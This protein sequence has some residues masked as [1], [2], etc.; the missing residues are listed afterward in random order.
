MAAAQN[1]FPILNNELRDSRR[2]LLESAGN[3]LV[4][5]VVGHG[6]SGTST[7]ANTIAQLLREIP[8]NDNGKGFDVVTLRA[9]D[10]I[11]EWAVERHKPLP[12]KREKQ[13]LTDVEVLQN[14]GDEMR[15]ERSTDDTPDHSAVARRLALKIREARAVA[16]GQKADDGAPVMPDGTHR[17]YLLDS[18]RHP[19]EVHFLRHLY[20][21]AFILVGVV[22]EEEKRIA[23]LH[24]KYDDGGRTN[25]LRF[26][27]R[28]ADAKEKYGQHVAD[29]F[30]LSDFFVDNTVDHFHKDGRTNEGWVINEHL[31]RL[32]K[33]VTHSEIIR[34]TAAETAM[35]HAY[36]AKMQSACLS[37]Q[38]GAALVDKDGNL[39]STG[40]NEVP[41][42]GGGVYGES[43]TADVMEGRCAI[44]DNESERHCHNT[45]KQNEIIAKLIETV[46]ELKDLSSERKSKLAIELRGTDI[47][48][49][50]EFSRAVHAEMDALLTAA[51]DG[52]STVGTRLFVT[53]YPCHYCARHIVTAG[54]DEV[55][56]IE[57]Y[58]KSQA[59]ALHKD[60]IEVE[61]SA[62]MV[63]SQSAD[64]KVVKK[65]LFHPFSCCTTAL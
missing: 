33:I 10:V 17:A 48:A 12:P 18:L 46:P 21:N 62:W 9:R 41:K 28:D 61:N 31:S 5:A 27:E 54:V 30:H 14:Y 7:V 50:L 25:A 55:Q 19:A 11:A 1:P 47:G 44:H 43:F 49:L 26:M 36:A 35:H 23:R 53:T 8:V 3:E 38:V 60:S 6:G 63:P 37:R 57:P 15:S 2:I 24:G 39:I 29:A 32:L 22:C 45:R 51:R 56:Y 59:V 42:A 20:P 52:I 13:L 58:P 65:V 16:V 34:P 4:F 40:A 64:P